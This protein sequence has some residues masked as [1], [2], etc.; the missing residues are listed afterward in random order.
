MESSP[1]SW[2]SRDLVSWETAGF[3]FSWL[4]D[5]GCI[6]EII[7]VVSWE[8]YQPYNPFSWK[9]CLLLQ[10]ILFTYTDAWKQDVSVQREQITM[11]NYTSRKT[12]AKSGIQWNTNYFADIP[13]RI[14]LI[15]WSQKQHC[16]PLELHEI[17]R[18]R[19]VKVVS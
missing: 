6:L 13:V 18:L 17:N 3:L 14:R 1:E 5:I 12:G 9:S 16:N 11:K 10:K 19:R 15:L 4:V 8:I 2:P 7:C